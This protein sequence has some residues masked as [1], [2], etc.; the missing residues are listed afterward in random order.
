MFYAYSMLGPKILWFY[1]ETGHKFQV[2]QNWNGIRQPFN[3]EGS[4]NEN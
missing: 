2:A 4:H 3:V 1:N